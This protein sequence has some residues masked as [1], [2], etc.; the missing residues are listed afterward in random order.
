MAKTKLIL[1]IVALSLVGVLLVVN[2]TVS[3]LTLYKQSEVNYAFH[4]FLGN[5]ED[6]A[7]EDDV[8]I[9]DNYIIKSTLPISDAYHTGDLSQLDSA[10]KETLDMAQTVLESIIKDDMSIYEKELAVYRYMIKDLTST[11]GMLTV[12]N[13]GNSEYYTPH[14]VLKNHSAI[15][16][17]YATTFRLFMQMLDIECMVV[18]SRDLSHSWNLVRLDDDNWYHTDCY[19]D[20]GSNTYMNFN[21]DDQAAMQG[22]AWNRDFFPAAMGEKYNYM[23]AICEELN[24]VYDVPKWVMEA[25][26]NKKD[27]ISCT[28]KTPITEENENLV[29]YMAQAVGEQL[30]T[31][32]KLVSQYQWLQNPDGQF[33]LCYYFQRTDADE[34]ELDEK[35]RNKVNR[36]IYETF[37]KY[38]FYN[39]VG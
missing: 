18:H 8:I 22:H 37:D 17:G 30:E 36:K 28:F 12:V 24:D 6:P 38:K 32:D 35:T 33:V 25:V 10:G 16:V 34:V 9:G 7:Q 14:D 1:K 5:T 21:M 13:T 39:S 11:K 15:C 23:F 20:A 26:K 4:K 27:A 3:A 29:R 19:M 2:L 31:N